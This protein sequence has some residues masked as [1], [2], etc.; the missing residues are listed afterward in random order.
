MLLG[1][2][3]LSVF[4][5]DGEMTAEH[6]DLGAE[7]L[8]SAEKIVR[9]GGVVIVATETFYGLAADPFHE[10]AVERI[11]NLKGRTGD[12]PL[13][14][15]ASD[16]EALELLSLKMPRVLAVLADHFWP[17]SL[18]IVME[19]GAKVSPF[20][21]GPRGKVGVRIPPP[22]P[23]Q[24]LALRVGGLIT[25]T[26]AN[27][28]GEPSPDRIDKIAA[29]LLASVDLVMDVG[30]TPGGRASTVVE[31]DRDEYRILR[32]GAIPE[33]VIRDVLCLHLR[34]KSS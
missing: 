11:F 21:R 26:S 18:T 25:A 20:L 17:G 29:G 27:L 6:E 19:A 32:G 33:Q 16:R 22:C 3:R 13:P 24:T 30:P 7:A 12:K 1:L 4:Q 31:A 14:L 23:A 28:S 34:G 9:A 2:L 15:I 5:E 10:E 8:Q